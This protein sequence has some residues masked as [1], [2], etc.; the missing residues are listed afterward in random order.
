MQFSEDIL[1]Q[2]ETGLDPQRP[3]RSEIPAT[4]VG[5]GEMTI[6]DFKVSFSESPTAK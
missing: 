5:F 4:V 6:F 2:F 1:Q 3:E